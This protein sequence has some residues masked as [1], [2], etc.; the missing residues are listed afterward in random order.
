MK[1]ERHYLPGFSEEVEKNMENT[2]DS[3]TSVWYNEGMNDE[4]HS[5]LIPCPSCGSE[6]EWHPNGHIASCTSC[7]HEEIL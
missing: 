3:L 6:M 2:L 5:D 1:N 7:G 4:T